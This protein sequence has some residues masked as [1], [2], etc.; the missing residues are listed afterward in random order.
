MKVDPPPDYPAA[1]VMC[2]ICRAPGGLPCFT[3]TGMVVDGRPTGAAVTLDR[4]HIARQRS[5][6]AAPLP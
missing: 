5:R 1:Y 2:K 4:P 3:Q 6:R